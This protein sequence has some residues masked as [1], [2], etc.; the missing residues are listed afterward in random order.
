MMSSAND[1]DE[2]QQFLSKPEQSHER[3]PAL[4]VLNVYITRGTAHTANRKAPIQ[5]RTR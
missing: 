1:I 2:C 5:P 3:S 4:F